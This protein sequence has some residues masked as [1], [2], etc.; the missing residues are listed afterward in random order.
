[1]KLFGKFGGKKAIIGK[2]L[3]KNHFKAIFMLP[4]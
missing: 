4:H 2:G 1:M 3:K